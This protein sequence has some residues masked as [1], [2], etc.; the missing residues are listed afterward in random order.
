MKKQISEKCPTTLPSREMEIKA[1]LRLHTTPERMTSI[2][3]PNNNEYWWARE[4]GKEGGGEEEI[5]KII[6]MC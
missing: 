1:L 5:L 2:K 6:K 3:K 4:K